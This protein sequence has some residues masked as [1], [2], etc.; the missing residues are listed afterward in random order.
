MFYLSQSSIE[1]A[2]IASA[3]V[4]EL[5][6]VT[7]DHV[8]Q[9]VVGQVRNIDEDLA[10]RVA[11]GI[12]IGL[13]KT[14]EPAVPAIK[15]PTSAALSIVNNMKATLKGR[16]IGILF[17][18]GSDREEIETLK[19]AIESAGGKAMLIAQRLKNIKTKGGVM[20]ADGQL[21]GTPSCILDAIALVLSE[22]ASVELS[23]EA[24]AVQFVMDAYGHLKAIGDN[25]NSSTLLK[26]AGVVGDA[27]VTSLG[28]PFLTAAAS[29]FFDREPS[30]R[31]LA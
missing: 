30:V 27:G 26:K 9:R 16:K 4:F 8:Q 5:S 11:S 12:G 19:S 13:P 25:G 7:L 21:F 14:I 15:L 1:Q 28:K 31:T 18:D 24:A 23:K 2:H 22:A 3:M 29:R 20:D 10:K 17:A 6:K